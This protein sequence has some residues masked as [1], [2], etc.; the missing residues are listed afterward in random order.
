MDRGLATATHSWRQAL[1]LA[2]REV[3]GALLLGGHLLL[4]LGLDL[5]QG[6]VL[7]PLLRLLQLPHVLLRHGSAAAFPALCSSAGTARRLSERC[8]QSAH[9]HSSVSKR[10]VDLQRVTKVLQCSLLVIHSLQRRAAAKQRFHI[11]GLDGQT[12]RAIFNRSSIVA[13]LEVALR[14]I[15]QNSCTI[16]LWQLGVAQCG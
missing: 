14:A 4:L 3:D 1:D 10:R 9:C 7:H 12:C 6:H 5:L 13:Q 8:F 15:A 16:N 11:V 2:E